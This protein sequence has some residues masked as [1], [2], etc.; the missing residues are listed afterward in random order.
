[1]PLP[2]ERRTFL[3]E[4]F[5]R[6][7]YVNNIDYDGTN[8]PT[9]WDVTGS[10]YA[11]ASRYLVVDGPV[12][13]T[14]NQQFTHN[15]FAIFLLLQSIDNVVCEIKTRYNPVLY[16][17][18]EFDF[19][20]D[21]VTISQLGGVPPAPVAD[22]FNFTDGIF[23]VLSVWGHD[24]NVY[25]WVNGYNILT[26]TTTSTAKTFS[27]NITSGSARLLQLKAIELIDSIDPT[28]ED[29][30]SNTLVQ[31]RKFLQ[32]E[33]SDV[34]EQNWE[35]YKKAHNRYRF[36]RNI[37]ARNSAWESMGYPVPK[38]STDAFFND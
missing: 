13:L 25:A 6:H 1:M 15:N 8:L 10:T 12:E 11:P 28:R 38:P 5:D 26:S 9:Y 34:A 3:N 37:G 27:I 18:T 35:A 21:L 19:S 16:T 2:L 30:T 32:D 22:S 14:Y 4:H 31:Y 33:L 29:E 24:N 17:S 20:A 7:G 36:N 23:Y